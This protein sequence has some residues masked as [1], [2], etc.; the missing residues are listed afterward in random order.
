MGDRLVS[1]THVPVFEAEVLELLALESQHVVV[2][3]TVGLG[4]HS[5]AILEKLAKPSQLI[6]LDRDPLAL[7]HSQARLG[8]GPRFV[9]A[10]YSDIQ[11]V[12]S[13]LGFAQC[14]RILADLG[15]SSYQIDSLDRGFRFNESA[16]LDMRMNPNEK[17]TAADLLAT[18]SETRLAELFKTY[19]EIGFA[20]KLAKTIVFIR[21]KTAFE[22]SDQLVQAIRSSAYFNNNRAAFMKACA[23]VFQALRIELNQELDHLVRFLDKAPV[24]LNVGGRLAIITFHSL[25]DRLVKH[26]LKKTCD[27][28]HLK[29]VN[30]KAIQTSYHEGKKNPRAKSAKL[31][32]YERIS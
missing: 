29:R 32:V 30:K 22:T 5:S 7:A 18:Y 28:G 13:Q 31:R 15:V 12:L 10:N 8:Q 17:T 26:T 14:D 24:C 6:A 20:D 19:G 2:D 4:G 3:A 27:E 21:K 9:H 11:G 1:F 16:P 23:Q 25:E